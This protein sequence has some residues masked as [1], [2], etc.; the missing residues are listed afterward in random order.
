VLSSQ[1]TDIQ[2][3]K[4]LTRG[5]ANTQFSS[6]APNIEPFFEKLFQALAPYLIDLYTIIDITIPLA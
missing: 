2:I 5:G 6:P 1:T 3:N 4:A